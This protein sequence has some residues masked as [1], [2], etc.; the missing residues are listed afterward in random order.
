[1]ADFGLF[2]GWGMPRAGREA[3]AG[4]VFAE[5]SAYW[6]ALKE[7]GE[8]ESFETVLLNYHGGDLGGFV[9]LRGDPA[10]LMRLSLTPEFLHLIQR[11]GACLQNVGVVPA[12]LDAAVTQFMGEWGGM[13]GDLIWGGDPGPTIHGRPSHRRPALAWASIHQRR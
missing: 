8:I 11:V 10:K 2:V 5:G 3:A 13:I 4:K 1:V 7:A 12:Y 6:N 9:L